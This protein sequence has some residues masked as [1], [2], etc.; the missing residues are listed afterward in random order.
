MKQDDV[1]FGDFLKSINITKTNLFRDGPS[2]RAANKLYVP[3]LT[4]RTLSYH[5]DCILLVNEL[6]TRSRPEHG[7]ENIMNYEFLLYA[8]DKKKRWAKWIKQTRDDD[9]RVIMD[10]YKYSYDHAMEVLDIL[11]EDGMRELKEQS[12]EGGS[13]RP[14]RKKPKQKSRR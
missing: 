11:G 2:L 1:K 3:F 9:I 4:M 7:L 6:N 12:S 8:I 13:D 14:T 10:K 5:Q